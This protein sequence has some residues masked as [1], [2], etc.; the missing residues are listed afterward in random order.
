LELTEQPVLLGYLD[1]N[2]GLGQRARSAF[3]RV[4]APEVDADRWEHRV[5]GEGTDRDQV[6]VCRFERDPALIPEQI[7]PQPVRGT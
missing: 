6:F 2:D 4:A 1:H 3:L 5:T 7:W